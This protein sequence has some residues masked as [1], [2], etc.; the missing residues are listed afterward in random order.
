MLKKVPLPSER[1][2]A[3][4][5]IAALVEVLGE[6]GILP[7]ACLRDTGVDAD[8]IHDASALTSVRQYVAVCRNALRLTQDPSTPFQ[9]GARLH[10]SAYG[11]YGYALMSCLSL[12]DY[13]NL[14]V[15]YHLLATPTL[16]I[17]WQESPDAAVW[18]FPDEFVFAPSGDVRQFL[19]EQ[20][21][22]QQV[23]HLQDVAGRPCPPT[24]ARFSYPKPDHAS[25]YEE[26]LHCPC[27]FD[28]ENCELRY[29]SD[30]LDQKPQ[31]AHRLTSFMFQDACDNLIGKAKASAGVAGEV[32]QILMRSPGV[33]PDMEDVA[34]AMHMTS[35]TLRRRL[36]DEAVSFTAIVDD[37]HRAVAMEYVAKTKLSYDD[38]AV[39]VGFSDV[40]NFRRAFKR[41]T[42]KNPGELRA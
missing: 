4:Y 20:Q 8:K 38:I 14:G 3:P 39:L 5:K 42:G 22:T 19:I 28:Q 41:W 23:T 9:V 17:A 11:M 7:E 13:F 16:T 15:K 25:I 29:D 1:I 21:F 2:Y 32:Y 40:A 26:Y 31:L 18:T 36:N 24:L 33:F 37:F 34:R 27:L 10:L 6:Q 30:I 12:R 35:R